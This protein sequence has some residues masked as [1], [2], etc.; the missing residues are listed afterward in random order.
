MNYAAIYE[1]DTA[2]G[3]G[4]RTALFVSGCDRHCPGCHNPQAWDFGFGKPFTEETQN[5]II[6]TMKPDGIDGLSILGGEPFAEENFIQVGLFVENIRKEFG[7]KKTIWVY[8]GYTYEEL[9]DRKNYIIPVQYIIRKYILE[10]SDVLVDGPYI[11]A[12]RDISLAFRGSRNQRIIDLRKTRES[13]QVC[14]W[15]G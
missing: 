7:N 1:Q 2:N 8:S 11:E 12:E 14:L 9:A 13:G 15:E 5:Y 4:L 6:S 10:N 3:P